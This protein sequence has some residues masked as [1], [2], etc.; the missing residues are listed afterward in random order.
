[1]FYKCACPTERG[2]CLEVTLQSEGYSGTST[3]AVSLY[4]VQ[5]HNRPPRL[6]SYS[7]ASRGKT[8]HR[9]LLNWK[10]P[11][12]LDGGNA[13]L[14]P[15]TTNASQ[16][17]LPPPAPIH[18]AVVCPEPAPPPAPAVDNA[19]GISAYEGRSNIARWGG[20]EIE[21]GSACRRD[22]RA[23]GAVIGAVRKG[24]VKY[25]VGV[26]MVGPPR[27]VLEGR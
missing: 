21:G 17:N 2:A 23:G 22:G 20:T 13:P 26:R 18:V 5:A 6:S 9:L 10:G 7:W 11:P 14:H 1:M 24:R 19:A 25:S 8:C 15:A 12:L 3:D 16:G 27:V 4:A